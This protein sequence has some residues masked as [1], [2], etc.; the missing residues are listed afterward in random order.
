M[1][2][3]KHFALVINV[4]ASDVFV[5]ALFIVICSA[6]KGENKTN[7]EIPVIKY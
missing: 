5:R 3:L 7:T 2:K 6:K 1:A 4:I